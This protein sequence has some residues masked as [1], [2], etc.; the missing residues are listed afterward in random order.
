MVDTLDKC[1]PSRIY[2]NGTLFCN[3]NQ[4][5][6]WQS[7]ICRETFQYLSSSNIKR[8]T[9]KSE[10]ACKPK[11]L[12]L[13]DCNVCQCE[14]N[15]FLGTTSCTNRK[16]IRGHKADSCKT[17]D[18]LRTDN[19]ICVCSDINYYIDSLCIKIDDIAV[20]EVN[21]SDINKFIALDKSL[22]EV[23]DECVQNKKYTID[24][25]ECT[26]SKQGRLICSKNECTTEKQVLREK[27][28]SNNTFS[29]LPVLNR[30]NEECIPHV[31]YRFNCNTCTCSAVGSPTCTTM[32][33]LQDYMLDL[34]SLRVALQNS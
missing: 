2:R 5:G 32:I 19:E 15:G 4:I 11:F 28:S 14:P 31:K 1:E 12:Y 26:C 22:E 16:C 27:S 13:I 29:F 23:N 17:G 30:S 7:D 3:C 25:N 24:C 10:V 6:S 18:F 20:Q 21:A 8:P 9:L 34:K 33:C